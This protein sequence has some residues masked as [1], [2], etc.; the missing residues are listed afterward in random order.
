[1]KAVEFE[2]TSYDPNACQCC[3]NPVYDDHRGF[4]V[5]GKRAC[6]KCWVASISK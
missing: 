6:L 4:E 5:N 3:K 2:P 1:M